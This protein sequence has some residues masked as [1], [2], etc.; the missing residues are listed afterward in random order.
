MPRKQLDIL[1]VY[2]TNLLLSYTST[3]KTDCILKINWTSIQAEEFNYNGGFA[4][5]FTSLSP[6]AGNQVWQSLEQD[7][8]LPGNP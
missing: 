6:V 2:Q 1:T 5:A 4:N 8:L 7:A 3:S